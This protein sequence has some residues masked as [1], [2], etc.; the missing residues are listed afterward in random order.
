[1]EA[2]RAETIS[3]ITVLDVSDAEISLLVESDQ[4]GTRSLFLTREAAEVL[5]N[6][7][8]L[9]LEQDSA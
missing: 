8:V 2:Q 6:V 7:L 5:R 1:M 9:A 4:Y 3:A